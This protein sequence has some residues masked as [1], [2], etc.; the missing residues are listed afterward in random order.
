MFGATMLGSGPM[1]APGESKRHSPFSLPHAGATLADPSA[2]SGASKRTVMRVT[3]QASVTNYPSGQIEFRFAT[4]PNQYISF[5]ESW[6]TADMTLLDDAGAALVTGENMYWAKMPIPNLFQNYRHELNGTTISSVSN[7]IQHEILAL[8]TE[9][10][11]AWLDTVGEAQFATND[12]ATRKAQFATS[13]REFA[14]T[15]RVGLWRSNKFIGGGTH[16][17]QFQPVAGWKQAVE[18][19]ADE[20]AVTTDFTATLNSLELFLTVYEQDPQPDG[21]AVIDLENIGMSSQAVGAASTGEQNFTFTPEKSTTALGIFYQD[22]RVGSSTLYSASHFLV[23]KATTGT[24]NTAGT[25][26]ERKLIRERVEYA[27]QQYPQPDLRIGT[28][29]TS[30]GYSM[31]AYMQTYMGN[32]GIRNDPSGGE[33]PDFHNSAGAFRKYPVIRAS[34][35]EGSTAIVSSEFSAALGANA[36]VFLAWWY[37]QQVV[38]TYS[39]GS[40]VAVKVASV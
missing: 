24:T 35:S 18:S 31:N 19:T 4:N 27:G 8:R 32:P 39:K 10:S 25:G 37:K 36:A 28:N 33:S 7:L 15:P 5:K 12:Y 11:K 13:R 22:S 34:D 23:D 40:I 29:L 20:K 9:E 14:W 38:M 3:P 30:T 16:T 17:I 6:F 1:T 2:P 21:D 26:V